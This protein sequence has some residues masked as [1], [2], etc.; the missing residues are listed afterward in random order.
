MQNV[1]Q[2][3]L[4]TSVAQYIATTQFQDIPAEAIQ[5]IKNAFIDTIGVAF[6]GVKEESV[7]ILWDF[8]QEEGGKENAT[9]WGKSGLK[10]S[11]TLTALANGTMAHA[12]DFDDLNA[13]S[14]HAHPSASLVPAI[15]AAG[16]EVN[17][18]GKELITAYFI[19]LE[20]MGYIG[21][22]LTYNHYHIGWHGT[23]TNGVLG[24]TAAVASLY[25][26]NVEQ[27]ENALGIAVSHVS[28]TRQNF[29]TMTKPFHAGK[30]AHSG[31]TAAKLAK[32]GFTAD[33]HSLEAPLGLFKLYVKDSEPY[34]T[35][36]IGE[37]VE[38]LET[39]L[40]LKKY[41]CCYG[42]HRAIDGTTRL[43]AH[44]IDVEKI[45]NITV[46]GPVNAFA[47]LIHKR[48]KTGL[49]AKFSLEFP[50]S[51]ILLDQKL[52]ISS[53]EDSTVLREDVQ[54]L[55]QKIERREDPS[56]YV[57]TSA[58]DEGYIEVAITLTDGNMIS[59]RV[60]HPKGSIENPLS[61]EEVVEKFIACV[62]TVLTQ[63]E[64]EQFADELLRLESLDNLDG[65]RS[66]L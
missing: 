3:Q 24:C 8:L 27:I 64:A 16:E 43:L 18:S 2:K 38:L 32:K 51:L 36:E 48:P 47:P 58:I 54:R 37:R 41:P 55:I 46:T 31:I 40:T 10:S 12:L 59:E 11:A 30:A 61:T 66:F 52:D 53:F 42:S 50:I 9:V 60:T 49:E 57:E 5:I 23:A 4:T 20:V 56:I 33:R 34:I 14:T 7:Q 25:K 45:R 15:L 19:G 22:I 29:G 35:K 39:K 62:Q 65:I 63:S 17:A 26:L 6:A 1:A 13:K 21:R 44:G 28:G